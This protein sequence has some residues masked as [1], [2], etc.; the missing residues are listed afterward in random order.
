MEDRGSAQRDPEINLTGS[1]RDAEATSAISGALT[2]KL[3][4]KLVFE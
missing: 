4:I 2:R 3:P 1:K